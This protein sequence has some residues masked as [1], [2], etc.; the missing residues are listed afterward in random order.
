MTDLGKLNWFLGMSFVSGKDNI[1][2]NQTKYVEKIL[3]SFNMSDCYARNI[4]CDPSIVNTSTVESDELANAT[5]YREIVGS[6]IYI[7]TGT[8]PDL[9]YVVTKLSQYMSNPTKAQLNAAKHVLKYL[10]GTMMYGL[11]FKKSN[12]SVQLQGY[13]DSD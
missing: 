12:E 11:T 9:C 1:E 7:M 4:P 5:L 3:D 2:V 10:K 6:L 8:R 13:C